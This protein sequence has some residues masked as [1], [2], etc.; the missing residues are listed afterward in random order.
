MRKIF[1]LAFLVFLCLSLFTAC[2]DDEDTT[3][4]YADL[5]G[6]DVA[7]G[8]QSLTAQ[9]RRNFFSNTGSYL[10]FTDTL[11]RNSAGVVEMLDM[12][13]SIFG[14]GSGYTYRYDYITDV[15]QQ[16]EA[17]QYIQQY[18][19]TKLDKASPF[20]VL[21]VNKISYTS[22][23]EETTTNKLLGTRA[24]AIS[25][26]EGEAFEDP[27]AYFAEMIKDIITD[28]M[29]RR[30]DLSD[31]FYAYSNDYYGE[32]LE[33]LDMEDISDQE[34][35]DLGF[36]SYVQSDWLGNY[37]IYDSRDLSEWIDA[38]LEYSPEEFAAKYGTSATMIN[39]YNTLRNIL[40]ELG[41]KL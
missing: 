18:L 32:Y 17:A 27:E 37:F 39:K 19:M 10:L 24:Y 4:S 33:D 41:F 2:G 21:A 1:H 14:N 15:D 6:F 7:D 9:I 38:L 31:A 28:Q 30:T 22:Y 12:A 16:R 3:P 34:L 40:L 23:G 36:F 20:S 13:Y 5:N 11:G 25:M 35:W 8:D 26:G 29:K